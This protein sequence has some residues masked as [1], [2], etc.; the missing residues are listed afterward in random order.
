VAATIRRKLGIEVEEASG[1][2]GE[3]TV[4]VDGEAIH[5]GNP[6]AVAFAIVPKAEEIVAAVRE[7]LK[8]APSGPK[9]A[10]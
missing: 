1:H 8:R 7:R 3:F 9:T 4:L 10:R 2:Y 5:S 6:V